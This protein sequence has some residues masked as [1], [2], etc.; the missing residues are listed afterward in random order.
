M[1]LTGKDEKL[2]VTD[3]YAAIMGGKPGR[4]MQAG[5][6]QD[7]KTKAS[8]LRQLGPL[9]QEV[10]KARG[11]EIGVEGVMQGWAEK[12]SR[13]GRYK[14]IDKQFYKDPHA[15]IAQYGE[16]D[17]EAGERYRGL[18]MDDK[19]SHLMSK[20]WAAM[21]K[22]QGRTWAGM[23]SGI[24]TKKKFKMEWEKHATWKPRV[25]PT[26]GLTRQEY[27]E[28]TMWDAWEL[29]EAESKKKKRR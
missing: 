10:L 13:F 3:D 7:I 15:W 2:P 6:Y 22:A 24:P 4:I 9:G 28:E 19:G 14:E 18:V 5:A 29:E 17:I 26:S 12:G 20:Q 21:R 23:Q 1:H 11:F 25:D 8:V 27:D 16:T